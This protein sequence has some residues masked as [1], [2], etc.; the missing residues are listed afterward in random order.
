MRLPR[1]PRSALRGWLGCFRDMLA[2]TSS[3]NQQTRT[4]TAALVCIHPPQLP[5]RRMMLASSA[6]PV[7]RRVVSSLCASLKPSR[8][9]AYA[10]SS[11]FLGLTRPRHASRARSTPLPWPC[12]VHARGAK[13]KA[14]VSVNDIPQGVIDGPPLPPQD[15]EPDYPPLLQQVRNNLLKF[16]HCVLLTRVGGFY[17]VNTVFFCQIVANS[18]SCTSSKPTNLHRS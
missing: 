14:T 3:S 11:L 2:G 1:A 5:G 15:D 16:N 13:R 6:K 12:L 10:S 9:R 8:R 7:T 17:E 18:P 4:C